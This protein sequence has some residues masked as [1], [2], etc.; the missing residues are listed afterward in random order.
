MSYKIPNTSDVVMYH[1]Y[2]AELLENAAV[3]CSASI[4]QDG[5]IVTNL[6]TVPVKVRAR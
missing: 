5:F 1:L 6:S 3:N 4:D 2:E